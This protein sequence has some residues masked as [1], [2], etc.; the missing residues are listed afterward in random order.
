MY[1][2]TLKLLAQPQLVFPYSASHVTI[3][4]CTASHSPG[5]FTKC[6][7]HMYVLTL[8]LLAQPQLVFP[9]SASHVTIRPC[10]ASHSPPQRAGLT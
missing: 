5:T 2:L 10:A 6:R 3:R 7:S 8:K 1:V 9:Y 4:P